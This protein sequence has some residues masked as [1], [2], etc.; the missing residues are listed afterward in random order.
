MH[1]HTFVT[2]INTLSGLLM[3]TRFLNL[4]FALDIC[5]DIS[6]EQLGSI[7]Q[8]CN[9]LSPGVG[10]ALMVG[11]VLFL[12]IATAL[13]QDF[14]L[15]LHWLCWQ[16]VSPVVGEAGVFMVTCPARRLRGGLPGAQPGRDGVLA[17]MRQWVTE[18]VTSICTVQKQRGRLQALCPGC[19][20]P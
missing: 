9:E 10:V 2:Q 14:T 1:V 6:R 20:R 3:S 15:R 11:D 12:V 13:I 5:L 17:V 4:F 7:P 19:L 8:T 16:Q 18:E